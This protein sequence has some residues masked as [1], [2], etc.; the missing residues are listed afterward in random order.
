MKIAIVISTLDL[1][2]AQRAVSNIVMNLPTD[3]EIDLIL[4]SREH[5]VYPYRGNIISLD[6]ETPKDRTGLLYQGKVFFKRIRLLRKLKREKAY[7]AVIS[8]LDSANVANILTGNKFCKTIVS[9]RLRLSGEKNWKFRL[10]V[11]TLVK[12]LYNRADKVVALSEG[13]RQDLIQNFGLKP[14]KVS[15]IYNCYNIEQINQ[16]ALQD[17]EAIAID[18]EKKNFVT[19]GRLSHQKGQWHLIRAFKQLVEEREDVRLY[20][21]GEGEHEK[22]LR[23]LVSQLELEDKVIF[24]GFLDNPFSVIARMDAFIFPSLYEGFGNALVEAM[25][26]GVPCIATDFKY[27]AREIF[28]NHPNLDAICENVELLDYGILVP[29]PS[30]VENTAEDEIEREE[31]I[32]KDAMKMLVEDKKLAEKYAIAAKERASFFSPNTTIHKW[33]ETVN[34]I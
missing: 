15:T 29:V 18:L 24:C 10:I 17:R 5:I 14:E 3:Y 30:E 11:S 8:F 7:N 22:Y 2:G 4:N 20:I 16:C 1:G 6:L 31:I 28:D 26:C 19:M 34:N 13:V 21:L 27:G 23:I 33:E 32:M 25:A 12:L 9:V